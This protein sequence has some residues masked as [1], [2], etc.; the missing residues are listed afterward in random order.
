VSDHHSPPGKHPEWH[1][2]RVALLAAGVVATSAGGN[3]LL[4]VGLSSA[5]PL[6]GF[7]PLPYLRAFANAAVIA[8]VLVLI[9]QFILELALLSWA[10][11]SYVLPVTSPSYVLIALVGAFGL[12]EAI[13]AVHWMGVG[14]ILC[15]VILVGRT[16]PLTPGSGP[17]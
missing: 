4:R 3:A 14:L 15:G 10:D 1:A 11:L 12:H 9:A 13:S 16:R 17:P 6:V 2:R 7:S 5:P 8:G